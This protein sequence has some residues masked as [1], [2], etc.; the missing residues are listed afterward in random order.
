MLKDDEV[1]AFVESIRILLRI[2][3]ISQERCMTH[4]QETIKAKEQQEEI[5]SFPF[6]F[7]KHSLEC[8]AEYGRLRQECPV[9][10]VHMPYGGDAFLLTRY[11]D[12]AKAFTD[13]QYD[14]IQ[15][16]DGNVPRL[17]A[18]RVAGVTEEG[19]SLFSVSN[20]RHNKVRRLVTQAFTV[21]SAN[22]LRP[23]VV[24]VTNE[25]INAM[26]RKG[27][28][29]DLFEDYA[30][31]TP[32]TVISELLG[33]PRK[34]E[35]LFRKS[36]QLILSTTITEQERAEQWGQM[37]QYLAGIIEHE[38]KQPGNSVI[39][40]LIKAREQGSDEVITEP[41]LYSFAIG[42]IAAGFETVS[43]TFT[44]SAFILLQRPELLEQLK[45]HI[46]D[47]EYVA[48]AIEELLRITPAGFGRPRITRSEVEL[49][50]VTIPNGEVV[51]LS[52]TS[53]NYDEAV[54][55]DADKIDLERQTNPMI[56]FGRGIHSC[57]G[58]QIARM[59][60]QVLWSTLLKRLPAI[61]LAV[62]TSEVPWRPDETLIFGP[63]ALP[64]TW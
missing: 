32:M 7:A 37:M 33:V 27:P 13:P 22:A 51:F 28:P 34:D 56:A 30:I 26:E 16:S 42:L 21:Q 3:D 5:L 44:N 58:Q 41:E 15:M 47:Q 48:L 59:E 19:E 61:R 31:Q 35:S 64:I 1:Q 50:G 4:E 53:A 9:A 10:K 2:H 24:E 20:A 62:P 18:G 25:L 36:A 54:F 11:A 17:E 46:D 57:I 43:T 52:S 63:A 45:G 60:M 23:R 12:V 6:P 29:A 55:Q 49:G 38:K 40:T 39:G 8:P 14:L